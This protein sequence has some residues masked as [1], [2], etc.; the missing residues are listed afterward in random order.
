MLVSRQVILMVGLVWLYITLD[1]FLINTYQTPSVAQTF[2]SHTASC[3]GDGVLELIPY[4]RVLPVCG[5]YQT[6]EGVV[7]VLLIV[8]S[9]GCD[10]TVTKNE[11]HQ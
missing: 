6:Y 10:V 11:H 1:S 3:C 5:T 8:W 7:S 4:L 2:G 9:R